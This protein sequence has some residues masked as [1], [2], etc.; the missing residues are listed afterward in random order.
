MTT[1]ATRSAI[2]TAMV[3]GGLSAGCNS[4]KEDPK[5]TVIDP[6]T[7]VADVSSR[8]IAIDITGVGYFEADGMGRLAVEIAYVSTP[9]TGFRVERVPTGW[10]VHDLVLRNLRP[11]LGG[12]TVADLQAWANAPSKENA[13]VTLDGLGAELLQVDL[14]GVTPIR[15]DTSVTADHMK[16]LVL[17]VESTTIYSYT[18]PLEV[19]GANTWTMLQVDGVLHAPLMPP[20]D[21]DEPAGGTADPVAVANLGRYYS[22]SYGDPLAMLYWMR[23]AIAELDGTGDISRKSLSV[24][25][26]GADGNEVS[27]VNCYEAFPALLYYFDPTRTYGATYLIGVTIA[28]EFCEDA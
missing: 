9:G 28:N 15:A 19:T 13:T 11:R 6:A 18:P 25:H 20:G 4:A 8:P 22:P 14:W 26:R 23:D 16:E 24:I 21:I 17:S 10:K 1:S 27:R 5:A 2:W 3:I 7:Y 12:S